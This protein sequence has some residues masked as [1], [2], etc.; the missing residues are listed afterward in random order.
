LKIERDARKANSQ[1]LRNKRSS[2]PSACVD[3][4]CLLAYIGLTLT[5]MITP[6]KSLGQNFLRD[7]NISRKIVD[8]LDIVPDDV[9]V[10]IG[11]GA[12]DFT[13]IL[14]QTNS[15]VIGIEVDPRAVE[16]LRQR[17]PS[18]LDVVQQDILTV[19]LGDIA[20][21]HHR[22]VHVVGNI[23]Y[24]IT[25]EILFWLFD[26]RTFVERATLMMQHEVAK[27]LVAKP[28]TKDYG[29]LTIFTQFY[30]A[31]RFLFKVSRNSFYPRPNVDSAVVQFDF[32]NELPGVDIRLFKNVVRGTFAAR[33]KTLRNGLK[34]L[35][36]NNE[37]LDAIP[38]DL[39]K[40]PENLT[41]DEFVSL[42]KLL[43]LQSVDSNV[44]LRF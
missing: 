19:N 18:G 30:A 23:P 2:S 16:I 38:F 36:F 24:Y 5:S 31:S 17:F 6:K 29:I 1:Q 26:Q 15:L 42:T 41:L 12:G 22:R 20:D 3:I 13:K 10:E 14:L 40:R 7:E 37:Q 35:G 11:P 33:R 4:P 9:V 32:A 28:E 39:T 8:N 44:H 27:R 34:P 21:R 25:T 43:M